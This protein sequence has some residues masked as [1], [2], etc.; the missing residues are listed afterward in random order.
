MRVKGPNVTPGYLGGPELTA[1]AFDADGW[2]RTGD[3]GKLQ[4][5]EDPN[6]GLVF[7]GRVV[8]DFKLTTGTFVS[9]GN[10]RVAALAAAS[11]LLMDAVICGHDRDY[12]AM[13]GW[14]N[15][16]AA[17]E[18]AGLPEAELPELVRSPAIAHFLREKL[19]AH[20]EAHPASSMRV[21]RVGLLDSAAVAGRQRD[22]RQGLRQPARRAESPRA[23]GRRAVRRAARRDGHHLRMTERPVGMPAVDGVLVAEA[24][25][26]DGVLGFQVARAGRRARRRPLPDP[27]PR[28]TALRAGA[29][30]RVRRARGDARHRGDG[31]RRAPAGR[32]GAANDTSFLRGA[33]GSWI[34]ARGRARHR[35]RTTWVWEIDHTDDEGRLCAVSRVTIAVRDR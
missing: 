28:A 20:N 3:A 1:K 12:V 32:D 7:D 33:R 22:H 26:L 27:G 35:G 14:L 5:P 29:R 4:D 15:L 9:V 23:R 16:G 25:C 19:R 11:P 2:Y 18:I 8:E 6:A 34:T 30:R 17:R 31:A 21:C 13:L 10:L 24:D